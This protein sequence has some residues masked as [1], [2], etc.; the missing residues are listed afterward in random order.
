MKTIT[1]MATAIATI[2]ECET[3]IVITAT[4]T[5][6]MATETSRTTIVDDNSS[7]NCPEIGM[8]IKMGTAKTVPAISIRMEAI[9]IETSI[10]AK[11]QRITTA[12]IKLNT[13]EPVSFIA[14]STN[15]KW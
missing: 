7:Y 14:F 2:T 5:D 9:A 8:D 3:E 10:V 15:S 6:A 11:A 4:T 13:I 1:G 12:I